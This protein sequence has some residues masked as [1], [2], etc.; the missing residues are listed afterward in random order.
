MNADLVLQLLITALAN[1]DKIGKLL[2]RARG[3]Q[4]D[5]TDEELVNLLNADDVAR[6]ALQAVIDRG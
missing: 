3:E 1:A 2:Q 4:R 6:K 5:V